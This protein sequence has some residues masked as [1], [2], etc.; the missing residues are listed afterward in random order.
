MGSTQL[1]VAGLTLRAVSV[2]GKETCIEVPAW[3]LAFDIGR[4]PPTAV[5]ARQVLF[6][7]SHIDHMGGVAHH[8][9]LRQLQGMTPPHYVVPAE[10]AEG[11]SELLGAWRKL[12]GSSLPCDVTPVRPGDEVALGGGRSAVVFRAVHRVA[13]VGY[14]VVSRRAVLRS[15]YVGLSGAM[16][17][18]ARERGDEITEERLTTELAFCGDTTIDVVDREPLVRQARVL[19]LECTFMGDDPES[20]RRATKTGHVHLDQLAERAE[21]FENE[22]IVLTHFSPRYPP[23]QIVRLLDEKLPPGLR[24]RVVPLLPVAPWSR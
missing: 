21:C 3:K 8:V 24:E 7:H 4:C 15:S 11:F 20:L 12:D 22:A 1:E 23:S 14:A 6:T 18:A 10:H 2:G 16:L 13:A 19:V 5:R 17:A 9:G